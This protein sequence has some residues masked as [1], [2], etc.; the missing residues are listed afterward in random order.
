MVNARF[1]R[2][3]QGQ[4]RQMLPD[5]C[6]HIEAWVLA[7]RRIVVLTAD[8]NSAARVDEALWTFADIAFVPHSV[9]GHKSS[10]LDRVIIAPGDAG[11]VRGDVFVNL[12]RDVVPPADWE[13][14]A[15]DVEIWEFVK[16]FD[17]DARKESH[18]KWQ[19]YRELGLKPVEGRLQ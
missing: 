3:E 17:A 12:T 15:T 9:L 7:G 5:L 6:R 4:E 11:T 16:S 1:V 8:N 14:A 2:I 10:S 18:R 13:E 19:R